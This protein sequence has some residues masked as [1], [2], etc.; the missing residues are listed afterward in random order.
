MELIKK[1]LSGDQRACAKLITSVENDPDDGE[2]II[3]EIHKYTAN[4]HI[5]GITGPP[6]AGKSTLTNKLVKVFLDENK[7]VGVIAVD[8]TSP[9]SGGSILGDRIR[10]QDL[11]LN[12]NV[13]IR[14][15]GTRGYLG[16]LSRHTKNAVKIL[17]AAG[18][19]YIIIETVGVG[20]SEVDVVKSA[21]TVVMVMVAGLGDDIQSMKAGIMEIG[22]IFAI[23]KSDLYGAERTAM[24]VNMMLDLNTK[25][26]R[27]PP[28]VMVTAVKNEG[29]VDL[30]KEITD[31]VLYLKESG[32]LTRR[33]S[34]NLKLEIVDL[35][36]TKLS[37]MVFSHA[38]N[39]SKLEKEIY[40]IV[41]KEKNVYEV[42]DELLSELKK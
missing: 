15:M 16:G 8:P 13:F 31:H 25:E 40:A 41:S 24:E 21:D 42:R 3:R 39:Q 19:D 30:A 36:E 6:G 11:A 34:N 23:N 1:L 10:M 27:R 35:V 17:D 33:R 4:A 7:K 37:R 32:E 22:D 12:P 29:I 28:V 2:K 14:S 38:S 5:I 18:Y 20:Q 26:G 9:Y